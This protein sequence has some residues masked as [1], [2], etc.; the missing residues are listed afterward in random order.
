MNLFA[1]PSARD[2]LKLRV[3]AAWTALAPS[4]NPGKDANRRS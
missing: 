4:S 3:D 2:G 1:R